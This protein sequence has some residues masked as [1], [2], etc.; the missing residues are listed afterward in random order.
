MLSLAERIGW[1]GAIAS[2]HELSLTKYLTDSRRLLFI[3]LLSLKSNSK[4]LDLGAGLGSISYQLAKR[5]PS[6]DVY[7]FDKT[8]EGLLL[9]KVIKEQEKLKNLQIARVDALEIPQDDSY[10]DIVMLVGVLEWVGSSTAG[11]NPIE[12]QNSVLREAY[13]VLKPGGQLLVGIENRFGHQYLRG[14]L[15]HSGLPYTSLM[16]RYFA[17]WYTKF[18]LGCEYRTHTYSEHGYRKLLAE[19]G[20]KN[21]RSLLLFLITESLG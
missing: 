2:N 7:A 6:C 3:P 14:T 20:F 11:M 21:I 18:R 8:L 10:F 19:A 5:N 12:A 16:P 1:K 4:I 9:L 17:N 15:D 13:R